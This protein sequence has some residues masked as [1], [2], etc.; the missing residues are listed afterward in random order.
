M[1]A[2]WKCCRLTSLP[3]INRV[4]QLRS[5]IAAAS[6][7]PYNNVPKVCPCNLWKFHVDISVCAPIQVRPWDVQQ[8]QQK[9]GTLLRPAFKGRHC[10]KGC[11][12]PGCVPHWGLSDS[13]HLAAHQPRTVIW[14]LSITL[15]PVHPLQGYDFLA[16][17]LRLFDGNL[18]VDL[19]AFHPL[20]LI[21]A[22]CLENFGVKFGTCVGVIHQGLWHTRHCQAS[23]WIT[24][25]PHR[26]LGHLGLR[27][28]LAGPT[29]NEQI[30]PST[31]SCFLIAL[32]IPGANFGGHTWARMA[33]SKAL[34]R[35]PESHSHLFMTMSK[36]GVLLSSTRHSTQFFSKVMDP[37]VWS[38]QLHFQ[39]LLQH[40][41]RWWA[42]HTPQPKSNLRVGHVECFPGCLGAT[43][44]FHSRNFSAWPSNFS[45]FPK[46][47]LSTIFCSF[48][49][50][51][52][53]G[54]FCTLR[55]HWAIQCQGQVQLKSAHL[56]NQISIPLSQPLNL[57]LEFLKQ[58][59]HLSV[60]HG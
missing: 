56:S 11:K 60:I 18:D 15:V 40:S 34:F 49:F 6:C 8:L 31:L 29:S 57:S 10:W 39:K 50:R 28:V 45:G 3:L 1:K 38:H 12:P 44:I 23:D 16:S 36:V 19:P 54:S 33:L 4:L 53:K 46:P 22:G 25:P 14:A 7:V 9:R 24:L 52:A 41:P 47:L 20:K 17:N 58:L 27:Q 59:G 37:I 51:A 2:G 13:L 32:R 35:P 21:H 55:A 48:S 5:H 42:A 26:W 30:S 43:L